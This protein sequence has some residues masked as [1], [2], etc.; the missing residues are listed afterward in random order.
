MIIKK[1]ALLVLTA[2]IIPAGIL[3]AR[4]FEVEKVKTWPSRANMM[5]SPDAYMYITQYKK[6]EIFSS[7]SNR[8]LNKRIKGNEKVFTSPEGNYWAASE[9][10]DRS[11][12][13]YRVIG[14][15]LY[16]A[17]GKNLYSIE[18][19]PDL[20]FILNDRSPHMVGIEGTEGLPETNLN[21]YDESGR[22]VGTHKLTH[23]LD[24]RFCG[25]GSL[26]FAYSADSG[27]YVFSPDGDLHYRLSSG[28][29]YAV[30][31]NG[32]LVLASNGGN[33]N[34]YFQTTTTSSTSLNTSKIRNIIIS[35]DNS[36]AI[37]MSDDNAICLSI[38]D[39]E[40]VWQYNPVSS[41]HHLSSC[42]YDTETGRTAIG[43]AIDSGPDYPFSER[44]NTGKVLILD[45][46]GEIM[47]S[48]DVSYSSWSK[49]F[50]EVE[51]SENGRTLWVISHHDLF[52]IK[53]E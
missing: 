48:A 12:N 52:K 2:L 7:P 14:L 50:P 17:D 18:D 19:P 4:Q 11:A 5:G 49:G 23:Y 3:N 26:F 51:F 44:Y 6:V 40:P 42:D 8:I 39:L 28:R 21:F 45:P 9:F 37:V 27:L 41:Y 36:R 15:S 29:N 38:P 16:A 31:R 30:N 20:K 22:I 13:Q 25:D 32:K 1:L 34:L 53:V 33:L 46:E 24:G 10:V 35:D 47:G 43:I